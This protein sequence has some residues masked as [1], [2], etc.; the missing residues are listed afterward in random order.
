MLY[1][2]VSL[3]KTPVLCSLSKCLFFV[4]VY[5]IP[6]TAILPNS[7]LTPRVASWW[8]TER[9][10]PMQ[11]A[12]KIEIADSTRPKKPRHPSKK[13]YGQRH[14]KMWINQLIILQYEAY[15]LPL[16]IA[17][18]PVAFPQSGNP[19]ELLILHTAPL[20][21]VSQCNICFCNARWLLQ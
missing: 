16:S 17:L 19:R 12:N 11:A 7:I 3:K 8:K 10:T 5:V 13:L 18:I 6:P 2:L 20:S 14:I 15:H 9:I 21:G 4:L 1:K